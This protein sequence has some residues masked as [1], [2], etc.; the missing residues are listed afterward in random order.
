LETGRGKIAVFKTMVKMQSMCNI[1]GHKTMSVEC[2]VHLSHWHVTFVKC[3]SIVVTLV[4]TIYNNERSGFLYFV[5]NPCNATTLSHLD[6][7]WKYT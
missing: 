1:V 7:G 2:L 6:T 3:C 5:W 4:L